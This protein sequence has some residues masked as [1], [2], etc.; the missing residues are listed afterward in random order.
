MCSTGVP[1][2]RASISPPI[3]FAAPGPVDEKM[4]AETAGDAGVA[5]RHVRAAEFAARHHEADGVAPADRIQH[6]DVVH[7]GDAERGGHA[8]L[9]EEFGH[10]IADG[11]IARHLELLF[12]V[13]T[14]EQAVWSVNRRV[15]WSSDRDCSMR[16]GLVMV[17]AGNGGNAMATSQ[18]E[19]AN[20]FRA[21][22]A[23]PGRS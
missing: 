22:H 17:G 15:V 23:A 4:H 14:L 21:L 9:R 13:V 6:R 10:Q 8:A 5:V 12:V 1:E 11:V 18:I 7:R 2:K 16:C 19:K 3:A 20:R